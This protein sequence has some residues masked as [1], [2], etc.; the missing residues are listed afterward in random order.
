MSGF[1]SFFLSFLSFSFCFFLFLHYFCVCI[2]VL[3]CD[4]NTSSGKKKKKEKH[5]SNFDLFWSESI[6]KLV[7][8]CC[9]W[10]ACTQRLQV[11]LVWLSCHPC[12]LNWEAGSTKSPTAAFSF[13]P[14]TARSSA[15]AAHGLRA[16]RRDGA[17]CPT[18]VPHRHF[19]SPQLLCF[20]SVLRPAGATVS[21]ICRAE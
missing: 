14:S 17:A 10:G 16:G 11:L 15:M 18:S 2:T 5:P 6:T 19:P 9:P 7:F 21:F 13:L 8:L 3:L 4:S 20:P 1:S 12:P